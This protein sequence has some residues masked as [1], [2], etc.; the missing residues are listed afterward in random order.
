VPLENTARLVLDLVPAADATP[1]APV[2]P[3]EPAPPELPVLTQSAP[4]IRTLV[5]DAGHGGNDPGARGAQGTV[6]KDVTLAVAQR[7]KAA[8]EARLGIR[9]VLTRDD[10]RTVSVNDRTALAN[11]NKAD[12]FVSLHANASL[13]PAMAGAA[14]YLASIEDATAV[15]EALA[16]ERLPAFGGGFRDIELVPWNL[17]QIRH[18]TRSARMANLLAGEFRN[19][20]PLAP[21]AINHAPIRVLEAANMPAVL[22]EMGYLSNP[23][24]E[25]QLAGGALQTAIAQAILEAMVK[26]R[27]GGA[28]EDFPR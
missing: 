13:R 10:D 9:V 26:F 28:A 8:V 2:A 23:E 16:S 4:A 5:I 1:P 19:G 15:R 7:L 17:A 14:I 3:L 27:D 6:E 20:V 22:I 24:Q 25:K 12:L 21:L 11:N 18:T